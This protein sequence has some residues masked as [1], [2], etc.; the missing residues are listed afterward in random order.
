MLATGAA[1]LA[2]EV[3]FQNGGKLSGSVRSIQENGAI[4][5][6]SPL[7][8]TPLSL[9]GD[10]VER[11]EFNQSEATPATGNTRFELVN[12]DF[13]MGTLLSYAPDI[14][15]RAV[16]E[17]IGE[18][19]IP[20]GTL[21]SISLDMQ[22]AMLIYNGPDDLSNWTV[23]ER[24]GNQNWQ[25]N[26][27]R[28]SVTGSGQIGRM[29]NLPDRYVVRMHIQWQGQ[30][31][32]QLGF[33]DPLEGQEVRVDRYYLQF[34]RAGIELKREAADGR[35]Y[36][37]IGILKRTPDQF[38]NREMEIELRVDLTRSVIHLAIN[39]N[40]EGHFMDPFGN[41]PTAGG[42]SLRSNA[43]AGHQLE[44]ARIAVESWHE[45]STRPSPQK[46]IMLRDRDSLMM[47]EGDHFGGTV[48][49]ILPTPQ[50][51]VVSMKVD[52]REQ[53]M[54]ILGDDVAVV[55]FP[56]T[57]RPDPN[58]AADASSR[59]VLNL[60]DRGRLTVTQSAFE[61][62]SVRAAHPLLGALTVSRTSV[63]SLERRH[64]DVETDPKR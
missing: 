39:G 38:P 45:L 63:S 17:G 35:R 44:I 42:I 58:A 7:A 21:N 61:D 5:L 13:L 4:Q 41:P 55:T 24:R 56:A 52:F 36:H 16:V 26:R 3:S 2:D 50:G 30:P 23:N 11:V 43:A 14:G 60:H 33:S 9:L 46:Q 27:Q 32:F 53:P 8:A 47:R 49:S 20:A 48:E 54:E 31:N 29:L 12:K 1:T 22:P 51:L 62:D 34:G 40:Q 59:F 6:E 10:A 37:T 28:L 57:Q 19:E 64:P 25:I 18:I 15:A